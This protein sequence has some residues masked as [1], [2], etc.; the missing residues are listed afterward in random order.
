[1]RKAFLSQHFP[2][3]LR[4]KYDAFLVGMNDFRRKY[5]SLKEVWQEEIKKKCRGF[6]EMAQQNLSSAV[7]HNTGE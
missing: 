4:P 3:L 6:R 7:F 5:D 1:M 2:V